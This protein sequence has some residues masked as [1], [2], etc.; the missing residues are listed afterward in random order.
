MKRILL[1]ALIAGAAGL[2]N[3]STVSEAQALA[4]FKQ[5]VERCTAL[6]PVTDGIVSS[7]PDG[8]WRKTSRSDLQTS[9]DVKKTDS[10]VSPLVGVLKVSYL[11]LG[12]TAASEAEAQALTL[13]ADG[14]AMR[15]ADVYQFALQDGSWVGLSVDE[16]RELRTR[17]GRPFEKLSTIKKE[18]SRLPPQSLDSQCLKSSAGR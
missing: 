7:A 2:A 16:S 15:V 6:F 10:L 3:A 8:K 12:A 14:P 9:F 4:N 1:A 17:A 18:A 11:A 5:V 13:D